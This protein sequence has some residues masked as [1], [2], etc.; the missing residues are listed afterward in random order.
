MTTHDE[1]RLGRPDRL[2]TGTERH[3]T[4]HAEAGMA[5]NVALDCGWGRL[6]FGN[7][8]VDHDRLRT[9]LGEEK[10]GRTDVAV[11][12]PDAHVLVARAPD[13]LFIDPSLAFRLW[14]HDQHAAGEPIGGVLVRELRTESDADAVHRL[15]EA[16]DMVPVDAESIL[17]NQRSR[18]FTYLVA[19]DADTGEVV[20]AVTGVDHVFAFRDAEAG[21]GLWCLAVDPAAD[22]SAVGEALIRRT[23][24]RHQAHGRAYLDMWA[25]HDDAS[26]IALL[27]KTGFER[28]P[29]F[30]VKRKNAVNEP[31]YLPAAP[32]E[33]L[34]I[35]ARVI[36]DEARRRNIVVK[37]LDAEESYLQLSHGGRELVT[38]DSLSELTS[39]V[40]MS[41]CGDKRVTRQLLAEVGLRVPRGREATFDDGDAEF[42]AELG[43]VVVKPV[44]GEQGA[45]V[46][47]G[48]SDPQQLER[49]VQEARRQSTRVLLEER[50]EGEDLRV[51]VIDH[52]V[53]AAAVRRPAQVVGTGAHTIA[54]LI[55]EE[56]RRRAE[57]TG[58]EFTIP[59]DDHT[60][61]TVAEAG[62][63][64]DDVL[65]EG[66]VLQV[67]GTANLHTGGTIHDVTERLHPDIADACVR[68]S[69]A[70]R[71]PV[72]GLDLAV[73]SVEDRDYVFIEANERPGL[74]YHEPQPT[75]ERF[76]DLLFPLT[77]RRG[78][79]NH[80]RVEREG[81]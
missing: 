56:S 5:C 73:P 65:P 72:V 44:Q 68:A 15:Y 41:W 57:A 32:E 46:T 22:R 40:A 11:Y 9:A 16:N 50:A 77:R 25:H 80:D 30:L 47:V 29:H 10:P 42:L 14:L 2:A 52:E 37:V 1:H 23:A 54:E 21:S 71:I 63:D 4:D 61:E 35:Y 62:H 20:G 26:T 69:R 12:V 66:E 53:V 24:E 39:A 70:L 64:L 48:V 45:G 28:V 75:V 74:A 36:A 6:L 17:A 31:L 67:R 38:Q 59:L 34:N 78:V 8:F 76:V 3:A 49:A 60:R 27:E 43:D 55:E 18:C 13:E 79:P 58:G 33:R 7:T 81:P 19:E 51:V